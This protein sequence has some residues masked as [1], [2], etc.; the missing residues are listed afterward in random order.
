MFSVTGHTEWQSIT[1]EVVGVE[2]NL[3]PTNATCSGWL[4][5]QQKTRG[6]MK[7]NNLGSVVESSRRGGNV[8]CFLLGTIVSRIGLFASSC[9]S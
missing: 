5:A 3:T 9:S 7:V 6:G 4:D 1:V 8:P 2:R